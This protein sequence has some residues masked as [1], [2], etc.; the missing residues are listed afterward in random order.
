MTDKPEQTPTQVRAAL[1]NPMW[2]VG[3]VE[4][5]GIRL[6]TVTVHTPTGPI[7]SIVGLPTIRELIRMLTQMAEETLK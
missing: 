7:T 1:I 5:G 2:E 6:P 3:T 4:F